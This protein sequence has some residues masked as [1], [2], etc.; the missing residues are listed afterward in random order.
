M[1]TNLHSIPRESRDTLFLLF[2]IALVVLGLVPYLPIWCSI[3]AAAALLW[4]AGLTYWSKALP[5]KI[6]LLFFLSITLGAT[7]MTHGTLLGRDAGVNLIVTLLTLK[8]LEMRASRDAFVIFFLGFFTLLTSFFFSQSLLTAA[9][10]AVAFW[11]LLTALIVSQMPV[12]RSVLHQAAKIAAKLILLGAPLMVLMFLLFPRMAPLWGTPD[13]SMGGRS[14]L[15]SS[16]QVGS[17]ANLVLDESVAMRV[18][19]E[20]EPPASSDLYFR[21]PVLSTFDGREWQM[22]RSAF[23]PRMQLKADLKAGGEPYSYSITQEASYRPWLLVIDG[24]A[25]KPELSGYAVHMTPELQ[26]VTNRPINELVRYKVLSHP[27][28]SHGPLRPTLGLQDYLDLP[29][30]FNPQT[31]QLAMDLRSDPR[32]SQAPAL[33][34]VQ[35]ALEKLRA[36]G[37]R[38]T[39]N[40]GV[41]G[42]HTADEFWFDRKQGFCEHIASAFVILMRA[43]DVPSRLVTGF[44]GGEFNPMNSVWTVR[45][46]DAHAW[47]EIWVEHQGWIRVD[48]TAA[49]AP[50][51]VTGLQRLEATQGIFANTARALIPDLTLSFRAAWDVVNNRW[52]Q[53]ILNYSEQQQITLLKTLGFLSP[54]WED[55]GILLAGSLILL[56]LLASITQYGSRPKKDL[57]LNMLDKARKQVMSFDQSLPHHATS[58]QIAERLEK[59][60]SD[61]SLDAISLL[62]WLN[63]ME[64]WRY[65]PR[66]KRSSKELFELKHAFN[67]LNWPK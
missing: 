47:A 10:M 25:E 17:I 56:T 64:E 23:P 43:L 8:T 15:S 58:R 28:F 9:T 66:H 54:S 55:L 4:R 18:T 48:P 5:A 31:L 24:T 50:F 65:S 34:M 45:N 46:S 67:Q 62:Q 39:L 11:G 42:K 27:R 40:P 61:Q 49:V 52:N 53:W 1:L 6:W 19:F 14:G 26:W 7:L 22:L 38:Y 41:Y 63:R 21:G 35:V 12:D 57:W 2:V 59:H 30:G 3:F 36:G 60:M 32:Y 51:R 37:Y 29:P 44:Q 16:L 20:G 13:P 33:V